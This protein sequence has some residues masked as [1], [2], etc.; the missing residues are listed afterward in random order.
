MPGPR[1]LVQRLDQ[2]WHRQ[3][4][5]PRQARLLV[6]VSGGADSVA[7]L[8]LLVAINRS[9]YWQWKLVVGHV[10]HGIRGR[11]SR[12]DARW[13]RDLAKKLKLTFVEK[14]V[15]L[16]R[17]TGKT[18]SEDVARQAR[19]KALRDM[20]REKRCVGVVMAHH[21]DDQ[22]ETVLM[23]MLRGC[24]LEGLAGMAD[25][26]LLADMWVYRPLLSVRRKVLREYLAEMGQAWREDATNAT[27][28]YLRN[29]VR[30]NLMPLVET[31]WP[32]AVDALGRLAILAREAQRVMSQAAENLRYEYHHSKRG[33]RLEMP[34]D[35]FW[36]ASSSV[37]A[38]MLRQIIKEVGGSP[39]TADFERVR[40]AVRMLQGETG[41][42]RIE[43]GS[44]VTVVLKGGG[45]GMVEVFGPEDRKGAGR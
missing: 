20:V 3:A 43:M 19:L 25:G 35:P 4:P 28:A 18:C 39:E 29:R 16:A 9:A 12:E 41:G 17:Q 33:N 6:A 7:L 45:S 2:Q 23:R 11:E 31:L 27:E 5:L 44:G 34:R 13:V 10:E 36:E 24:G 32:R 37:A 1:G 15:H 22:A 26:V 30:L 40:E 8:R 38:E 42:K 21:A 14:R